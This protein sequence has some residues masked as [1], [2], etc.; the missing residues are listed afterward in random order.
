MKRNLF[1]G[2]NILYTDFCVIAFAALYIHTHCQ[3]NHTYKTNNEFMTSHMY[4]SVRPLGS[5]TMTS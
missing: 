1:G 2:T 4:I 3:C 5:Y